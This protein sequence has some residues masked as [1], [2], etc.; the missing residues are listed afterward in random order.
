M[1]YGV[2][3]YM[4]SLRKILKNYHHATKDAKGRNQRGRIMHSSPHPPISAHPREVSRGLYEAPSFGAGNFKGGWEEKIDTE[5]VV[6]F[7]DG[8]KYLP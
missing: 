8:V 1:L 7:V 3:T 2:C 4:R 6:L 5:L